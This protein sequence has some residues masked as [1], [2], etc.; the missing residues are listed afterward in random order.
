MQ[1]SVH[2]VVGVHRLVQVIRLRVRVGGLILVVAFWLL[3]ELRK[4]ER[5][6]EVSV[7]VGVLLLLV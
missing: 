4:L 5:F 2:S 6:C 3:T 1:G 7:P